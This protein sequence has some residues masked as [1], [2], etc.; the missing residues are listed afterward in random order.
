MSKRR[1][2]TSPAGAIDA[3]RESTTATL[4]P[5]LVQFEYHT[6]AEAAA[7]LAEHLHTDLNDDPAVPGLRIP[8]LFIPH[9][10]TDGAPEPQLA[11][12]AERVLVVLLADDHLAAHAHRPSAT[13]RTWADYIVELRRLCE[14]SENHRFMPIQLTQHAWPIDARLDDLNFLRAWAIDDE[15]DRRRFIARRIVQLL[16]RRLQSSPSSEDAPPLTIFLSHT[17]L[18]LEVEPRV[19]KSLLAHLTAN[20]PQKT[21][22]D[23]GDIEV[24]SRFAKEIEGGVEDAALLAVLTD[25]YS[26]RS[27]CRRE[28]LLAKHFQRPV[29]VVDA[30]QDR[31]VRSFP[32][33]G[34]VPVVRWKG[35]AQEVIDLLLREALRQ[36]FA[37]DSLRKRKQPGDVVLPAGPELLTLVHRKPDEVVLYPDPPLGA[38]EL[39]VIEKTGIR[40]ETPLERHARRCDLSSKSFM[41]AL[42]T[43]PAEDIA[44]FGLRDVHL[45]A[46]LLEVSR[47]LLISG[48]RIAYGGHLGSDGYTVRLADLLRDPVVEHLR[49][50]PG[51]TRKTPPAELVNYLPWPT[52]ETVQA[53]ARLGP[54]VEII[55]CARPG[56]VDES[57]DPLLTDPVRADVAADST[58]RRF[59]WARGLTEMR[60][61]QVADIDGRIAIAGRVGSGS[62][63]YRGRMPGVLEEILLSIQAKQPVY[64]IGAYGGCARLVCEALESRR[65]QPLPWAHH[66][67]VPLSEELRDL[68][69]SKGVQW[70]EYESIY[71]QLRDGGFAILSN[72]L[73]PDENR[74][75]AVTRST[76]RMIELILSGLKTVSAATDDSGG[77]D[78]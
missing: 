70:D 73:S 69:R 36:A 2:A 56:D 66:A 60:R 40:V 4:A 7:S 3:T 9:N 18:D 19:V 68:Y 65:P 27:W 54:L 41:I 61:R 58:A 11:V 29:V 20:Q 38:E 12:E 33:V 30:V 64:L 8:T 28:V 16:L 72:G 21:W 53:Q 37:A 31:E 34:N 42:S 46:A 49:G 77:A 74:E 23:S 39:A 76:E 15:Q 48:V 59:A 1:S 78:G 17:K 14:Q 50:S 22:F 45:E 35:D 55:L 51:G 24:G 63:G 25:S 47:Y 13:G 26:S 32:Y 71:E 6:G 57:L 75:L 62:N 5:A 67:A 10:G 43:S 52:F 44:R